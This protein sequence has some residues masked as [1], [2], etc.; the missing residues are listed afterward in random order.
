[1]RANALCD[2]QLDEAEYKIFWPLRI[3]RLRTTRRICL[4]FLFLFCGVVLSRLSLFIGR[5]DSLETPT[6]RL[7]KVQ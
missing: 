5:L 2:A 3:T 4:F 7:N 6:T 1:M